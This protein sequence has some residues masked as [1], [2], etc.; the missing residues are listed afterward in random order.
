MVY[1]AVQYWVGDFFVD[2]SRNQITQ[3]EQSKTI[4]P[5]ALAVLTYLAENQGKVLSHNALLDEVWQDTVVS[6]NT[7][8]RSIA[9][10]RKVFGDDG[11]VQV[12]I[13]THAKQGYSLECDVRWHNE[14]NSKLLSETPTE[15]K[16]EVPLET[17]L[18][19][20]LKTT[21]K[22]SVSIHST[23]ENKVSKAEKNTNT[24][25]KVQSKKSLL[26]LTIILA[27][28]IFMGIIGYQYSAPK[29]TPKLSFDTLRSLTATDNKEHAAVYSP[30]GQYTIFH[31]Y[32]DKV[33]MNNLWAKN[34]NT[35][36]E[37][38]LTKNL[39]TYGSHRFS[40]DGKK[41]VFISTEDCDK[42]V[43]SKI[44][45]KNCYNLVTLDFHKALESSQIPKV[46]VQCKNS[47][48]RDP[49]WLDNDNIAVMQ[50]LS[51]SWKIIRYSISENKSTTL[52]EI[53]EGNLVGFDY[54]ASEDL[55]AIT[56]IHNDGKHYIEMVKPNGEVLSSKLIEYPD[57]ISM[58]KWIYPNFDSLNQQLIFSSGRLLF[59][60]SY[61]GKI[62]KIN[63]P[64]S[65]KIEEPR[66]HPNGKQLL[67][68]KKWYDSDIA[69]VPLYQLDQENMPSNSLPVQTKQVQSSKDETYTIIERSTLGEENA[70][71]QPN[72]ELIAF[73]SE[74][75]GEDQVWATSENGL[76]KVS[77]FPTNTFIRGVDWATDGN[78]ILV[79]AN[80]SLTQLFLNKSQKQ[81][82]FKHPIIKLFQWNSENNTALLTISTEGILKFV[83]L[84]LIN[85]EFRVITDKRVS[86]AQKSQEGKLIYTDHLNRFWQQGPIEDQLIERLENQG[87]SKRFVVKDNVVYGINK[88]NQLWS[89][90]LSTDTFKILKKL[91]NNVDNLTDVNQ[92]H[93]LIELVI[94]EKKEVVELT[95][96]Q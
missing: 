3:K 84:N 17:S 5:K 43:T 12:Y 32:T 93:A 83:E 16:I 15:T 81:Y 71:F 48:L 25:N 36:Q 61:D 76:N 86:W 66:F 77:S 9:Q 58:S 82:S 56:S 64:I 78:S 55:I 92:S 62:N 59:T 57:G 37:T 72:G 2:L 68:I 30:D 41:L 50:K 33:C 39:G 28:L 6:T 49:V 44:T 65:H 21:L 42:P 75:T 60:L 20:S 40:I 45:K 85:S 96:S 26:K 90:N 95:L 94:A 4:A 80:R 38:Q 34:M 18:K 70:I 29:Q 7:L 69:S 46:L 79:N 10:L 1:M 53:K 8:Q 35:Q 19:A 67:L 24:A 51:G 63:L 14:I 13:K 27:G 89:Y 91:N 11:K 22:E 73:I 54:S 31:R 52:L 47:E 88:E 74:R 87:S 23:Q